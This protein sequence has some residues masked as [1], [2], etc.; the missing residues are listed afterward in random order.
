MTLYRDNYTYSEFDPLKS[1]N[2]E[3]GCIEGY[4]LTQEGI[5]F[6]LQALNVLKRNT[7]H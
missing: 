2:D 6:Y 7:E 3:L 1:N 5:A 4:G